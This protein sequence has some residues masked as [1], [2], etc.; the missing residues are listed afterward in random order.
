LFF[1][2]TS[3]YIEQNQDTID[4]LVMHFA[5]EKKQVILIENSMSYETIN[6][7]IAALQCKMTVIFA[8]T[9]NLETVFHSYHPDYVAIYKDNRNFLSRY[10]LPCYDCGNYC[11]INYNRKWHYDINSELAVMLPTSGSTGGNKMVRLSYKNLQSNA[12]DICSYLNMSPD[13]STILN[14]PIGYAYGL[15][16]INTH[17]NCGGNVFCVKEPS[18][19]KD[20][21]WNYFEAFGCTSINHVPKGYE[22]LRSGIFKTKIMTLDTLRYMTQAGG[23]LSDDDIEWFYQLSKEYSFDFYVMYGQTEATARI[24]YLDPKY[25]P[26]RIGSVGHAVNS[27]IVEIIDNEIVYSGDNVM[28]GY[29]ESYRDLKNGYDVDKLHTGD[30]GY[31]DNGFLYIDGRIS[32]FCKIRGVRTDLDYIGQDF[33]KWYGKKSIAVGYDEWGIVL[34]I[35]DRHSNVESI[36]NKINNTYNFR[37]EIVFMDGIPYT[38]SFK[39]DYGKLQELGK[40]SIL[41]GL[42]G[43][44]G[45][46]HA[47]NCRN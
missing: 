33:T 22:L 17:L 45:F 23:K 34:F 42:Q 5:S 7:Y 43:E 10:L 26:E 40:P 31:L 46:I 44:D 39:V 35:N 24:S 27:G 12:D 16:L 6:I 20:S 47:P 41:F 37:V 21:F 32:R 13:D 36:Y 18:V 29:A 11:I 14:L 1:N 8:D 9:N 38:S 25:L 3:R 28:M 30:L 19:I 15:S 2:Q 4:K